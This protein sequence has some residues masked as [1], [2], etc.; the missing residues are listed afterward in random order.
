M[1][2]KILIITAF[3]NYDYNIRI[4]YLEK[5][6]EKNGYDCTILS[7]NF[8]HRKKNKYYIEKNSVIQLD[9]PEYKSNLSIKRIISHYIFS[10]K[11]YEYC[12]KVQPSTIYAITPPN[13]MFYFLKKFKKN[14]K[15][16]LIYEIEDLWPESLPL[17]ICMKKILMPIMQIWSQIRNRNINSADYVV[18]ECNLFKK[19]ITN[20]SNMVGKTI[21]LSKD[22][23]FKKSKIVKVDSVLRYI[24]LGSINNL[25][26]ID[27][28]IEILKCSSQ[29]VQTELHIIGEGEKLNQLL[30][31]CNENNIKTISYGIVYDEKRKADIFRQCHLAL[32]IMKPTVYVGA[33]MKSLEYFHYGMPIINNIKGD[34]AEIINMYECGINILSVG[35]IFKNVNFIVENMSG[36][37]FQKMSN[38]SRNVYLKLFSPKSFEQSIGEVFGK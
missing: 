21:Y 9:V 22:D 4:K 17:S 5:Y 33:T 32:N 16:Y 19:Y 8:D 20:H 18:F 7:S 34:T 23:S 1:N 31:L 27:F 13:F 38:N 28:I 35:E 36:N 26:D 25:I 12:M 37:I 15:V 30:K 6:L 24:Y 3:Y 11:M 2:N 14:H 10:K 29:L